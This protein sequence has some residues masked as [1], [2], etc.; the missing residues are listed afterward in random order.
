MPRTL[1][2]R[3]NA[4]GYR[5]YQDPSTGRWLTTHRAVAAR[6]FG[7]L[8]DG[9]HVHHRDGDKTNNRR[10]NLLEAHP[11]VHGRLH[12]EPDACVRCGRAGHWAATCRART[13]FDGTPIV[14]GARRW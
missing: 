9:F 7:G 3:I 2:T 4:D 5:E 8:R 6:K 12:H 11:K 1:R 10:A 14:V 13:F